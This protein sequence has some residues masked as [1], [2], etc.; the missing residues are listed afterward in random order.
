VTRVVDVIPDPGDPRATAASVPITA[1]PTIA[2]AHLFFERS[3]SK[4][5]SSPERSPLLRAG[6]LGILVTFVSSLSDRAGVSHQASSCRR[7]PPPPPAKARAKRPDQYIGER[8]EAARKDR[9]W[10][11]ADLVE[12]LHELG[13][14][15]WRQSKV[16][17][18]ENG[19]TKRLTL[20][21]TLALALA[22]GV[23]LPFLLTPAE[24]DV[25]AAPKLGCTPDVFR[26][27]LRG[28]WP[29]IAA[30]ER[31][32]YMGALVPDSDAKRIL[33]AADKAGQ[34]VLTPGLIEAGRQRAEEGKSD[35]S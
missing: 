18:I 10:R 14:T 20:E 19:E 4:T 34:L 8:V 6:D 12:R 5:S 7:R 17:K 32:F 33:T 31:V 26:L 30:D 22:L 24:G 29:L 2:A 21:D 3:T 25:E 11:Q 35:A 15:Q 13:F 1:T 16:A 28:E 9:S 27:W 23:Q